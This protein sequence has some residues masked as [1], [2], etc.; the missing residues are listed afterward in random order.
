MRLIG[1]CRLLPAFAA[2]LALLPV[3]QALAQAQ[4]APDVK[5]FRIGVVTFLS[6]AAAGPF[7]VPA[8]NGA[9]VLVEALNAG[10]GPGAVRQKRA[11]AA[12]PSS[13]SSSTRPAAPPSR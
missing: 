5:P 10:K 9:E 1:R 4:P 3:T 11:S 12:A 7:G 2:L 13:W 8:R 6:G